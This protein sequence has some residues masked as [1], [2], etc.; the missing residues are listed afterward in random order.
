[1]PDTLCVIGADPGD[2]CGLACVEYV[3]GRFVVRAAVGVTLSTQKGQ[4]ALNAFFDDCVPRAPIGLAME[5]PGRP[6]LTRDVRG[7]GDP[8]TLIF[9]IAIGQGQRRG[10]IRARALD[11]NIKVLDPINVQHV[12]MAV[13]RGGA[14]KE[15]MMAAVKW[16]T[17]HDPASEHVA[18]A[19]AVAIA[20]IKRVL[21]ERQQKVFAKA[22]TRRR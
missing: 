21:A 1:M 10:E 20:A 12:K 3:D 19:I 4:R 8:S 14:S 18:D 22:T 5:T 2:A 9:R 6:Y 7:K 11:R 17:G 15:T 16:V 13:A